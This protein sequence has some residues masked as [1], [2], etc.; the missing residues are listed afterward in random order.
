MREPRR[1]DARR[2]TPSELKKH[3]AGDI[4]RSPVGGLV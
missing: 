4:G 1:E 3:L 2:R